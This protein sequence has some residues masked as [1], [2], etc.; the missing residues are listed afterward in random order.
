M[1]VSPSPSR[2]PSL[3]LSTLCPRRELTVL[4][5]YPEFYAPIVRYVFRVL[6]IDRGIHFE[7]K[8]TLL[9]IALGRNASAADLS[10]RS[11][12]L[13]AHLWDR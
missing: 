1:L 8:M 12:T 4:R 2:C 13:P 10:G 3:C 5:L 11:G 9:V 7:E 6:L